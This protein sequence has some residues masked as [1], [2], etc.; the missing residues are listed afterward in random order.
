MPG[1]RIVFPRNA[2]DQEIGIRV[3]AQVAGVSLG[4]AER[5][6]AEEPD[7]PIGDMTRVT[8]RN[9]KPPR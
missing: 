7:L 1:D 4:E 8:E 9:Q 3:I 6:L 2:T 5:I